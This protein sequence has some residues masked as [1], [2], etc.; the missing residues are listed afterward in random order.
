MRS[1]AASRLIGCAPG[2]AARPCQVPWAW[3]R[4]AIA[5]AIWT[6]QHTYIRFATDQAC[7]H[8][9]LM[10]CT[11]RTH[12]TV[13]P[14]CA[15]A[16]T[17]EKRAAIVLLPPSHVVVGSGQ[18]CTRVT[19]AAAAAATATTAAAAA[20]MAAAAAATVCRHT[21]SVRDRSFAS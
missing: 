4:P 19:A 15:G 17:R 5:G 14:T 6:T 2:P 16:K 13:T 21:R 8:I 7:T 3:P 10:V 11:T 18:L 9:P 12:D 1:R 20:A